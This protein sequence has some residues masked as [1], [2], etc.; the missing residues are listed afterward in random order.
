VAVIAAVAACSADDAPPDSPSMPDAAAAADAPAP[1]ASAPD[2]TPAGMVAYACEDGV[3]PSRLVIEYWSDLWDDH[4]VTRRVRFVESGPSDYALEITDGDGAPATLELAAG[5]PVNLYVTNPGDGS[6]T[7]AHA[8]TATRLFR[9][10]AWRRARTSDADWYAPSYDAFGVPFEAG[11]DHEV[12][13]QFVPMTEGAYDAYCETGVTGGDEYA[14]IAAGTV[15]P[16]LGAPGSH[17]LA[18]MLATVTITEGLGVTLNQGVSPLRDP[19]LDADP[20]RRES[21]PAWSLPP[22]ERA[23]DLRELSDTVLAFVPGDLTVAAGAAYQLTL[24]NAPENGRHYYTARD[25]Y[26]TTV[27]RDGRDANV[28]VEA[29][30]LSGVGVAAGG[31]AVVAFVPTVPGTFATYCQIGVESGSSGVDLTTGHAGEGM[32]GTMTV[33]P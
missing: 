19:A 16:D 5:A 22:A 33:T 2:L 8:F 1:D 31:T 27:M 29:A 30:Y 17:S 6:S 12:L 21:D 23:V 11:V 32:I 20:R 3:C 10:V 13:L 14:G 25:F 9:G 4:A 26:M 24:T 7:A 28:R 18:G 15:T